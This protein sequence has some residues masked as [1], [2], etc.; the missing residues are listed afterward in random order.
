[1][2]RLPY[3]LGLIGWLLVAVVALG[4]AGCASMSP[5]ECRVADWAEQGYKDGRSG[6]APTRITEHR[7]ACA[8][9]GVVPDAHRYRLGWD[10]GVLEYCT[11]SH[12]VA[13][14]RAG[15]PYRNV[16]PPQL[17]GP[18]V[19]AHQLG[20]EVYQAQR[21]VDDLERQAAQAR[22]QLDKEKDA[23]KRRALQRALDRLAR[24]SREA[25][26]DLQ[27]AERRLR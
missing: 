19:Q 13:Q 3:G 4:L 9:A 20:M 12:G 2:N 1:M 27:R 10:R 5:E 17:E 21:R 26:R 23:T 15:Q 6:F 11:P 24:E 25:Q 7:K 16:C 18:F 14:G 22:R 8:E